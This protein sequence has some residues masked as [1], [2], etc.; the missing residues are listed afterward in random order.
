MRAGSGSVLDDPV[1]RQRAM[2]EYWRQLERE[3]VPRPP[4]SPRLRRDQIRAL[5]YLKR[6]ERR[7]MTKLAQ[8]AVDRLLAEHGGAEAIV[9]R[10]IE[11]FGDRAEER[12][13]PRAI[14]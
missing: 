13:G 3:Q 6:F 4:Y 1:A 5:Y 14:D 7:P 9:A 11:R 12:P 2:E 8:E 10:G